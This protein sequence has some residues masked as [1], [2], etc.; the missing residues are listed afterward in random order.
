MSIQVEAEINFERDQ[1]A[2]VTE[3]VLGLPPD[4]QPTHFNWGED[5]KKRAISDR[6]KVA[7]KLLSRTYGFFL[8]GPGFTYDMTLGRDNT[9]ILRAYF[10]TPTPDVRLFLRSFARNSPIFGFAGSVEERFARNL[11][12]AT[13]GQ[14]KIDAWVGRL[15]R[16]QLPG[17]YWC[18]LVSGQ[19]LRDLAIP[20]SSLVAI[21]KEY[22]ELTGDL[23]L[24]RFYDHPDEWRT[25]TAVNGAIA[26]QP[27]I[28][29]VADVKKAMAMNPDVT[30]LE[31]SSLLARWP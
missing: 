8:Y 29:D 20:L 19:L 5:E 6:R 1:M 3:T 23:H 13:L 27:G 16:R 9:L 21:A 4:L 26:D 18:T 31:L 12:K 28:F 2:L 25:A 10:Y 14:N 17:L 11:V 30:F 24:F 15:P 7:E 22:E